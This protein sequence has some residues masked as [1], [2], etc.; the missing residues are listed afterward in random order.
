MATTIH[1]PMALLTVEVNSGNCFWTAQT[2][3]TNMDKAY[4]NHV[5]SGRSVSTWWMS[6]PTNVNATPAWGL[7]IVSEAAINGSA[8]GFLILNVDGMSAAHGE[9]AN[10]LASSTTQLVV[11]GSFQLS[12]AGLLTISTMA[13]TNFD[14]TLATS[15]TDYLKVKI[16][17]VGQSDTL[18]SDWYIYDVKFRCN[19][20]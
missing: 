6:V 10:T 1:I 20:N 11:A 17:R 2:N 8:G 5:D 7:D 12:T 19:V 9:S 3:L 14:A 4:I 16:T 13:T 18:N 15:A